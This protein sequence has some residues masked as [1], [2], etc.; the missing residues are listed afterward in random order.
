[1]RVVPSMLHLP[2]MCP[3]FGVKGSVPYLWQ[4]GY[5]RAD[6]AGSL[7]HSQRRVA[8]Y[9]GLKEG[10]C[11]STSL[12]RQPRSDGAS[13]SNLWCPGIL[14]PAKRYFC[15]FLEGRKSFCVRWLVGHFRGRCDLHV[16]MEETQ[17]RT[18]YVYTKRDNINGHN[19][20]ENRN[21]YHRR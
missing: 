8:L 19:A 12:R 2:F 10:T 20:K 21:S 1:M 3:P 6:L 14:R 15:F 13:T 16:Q 9:E 17:S 7:P 4:R 18:V 11:A 5:L